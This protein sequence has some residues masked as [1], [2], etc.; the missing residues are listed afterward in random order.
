MFV[1]CPFCHKLV[2][3]WFYGR[4]ERGHTQRKADGQMTEHITN[5]PQNRFTG[6]LKGEPQAYRHGRCGVVTGM[7]EEIIRS[8]LVDPLLYNDYTFCCGCKDYMLSSELVWRETGETVM[9]YMGRLRADY[10]RRTYGMEIPPRMTGIVVTPPAAKAIA[11]MAED[12]HAASPYYLF[13]ELL[14]GETREEHAFA[15]ESTWDPEV[16]V[17]SESSGIQVVVK[18]EDAA[19]LA[20][21]II[22]F[23][24][25][26]EPGFHFCR[27]YALS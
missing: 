24:P 7:P 21:T 12:M 9:D 19:K 20:G 11:R 1:R 18:K 6:S 5:A 25:T 27:L 22:S 16:D 15:F 10:L 26:P 4:H 14:P 8:Y 13:L 23:R 2:L 17:L 3:R